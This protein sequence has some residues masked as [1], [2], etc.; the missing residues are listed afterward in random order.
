M[1][2]EETNNNNH[3]LEA[4]ILETTVFLLT[5]ITTVLHMHTQMHYFTFE[6]SCQHILHR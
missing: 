6:V 2:H 5:H 4:N 3:C 1:E